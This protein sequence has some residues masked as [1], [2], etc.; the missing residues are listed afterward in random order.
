M[1]AER[2]RRLQTERKE[3]EQANLELVAKRSA[4]LKELYRKLNDRSVLERYEIQSSFASCISHP[5]LHYIE[6][7]K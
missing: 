7:V 5:A 2:R 3:T 6:P 4:K 1:N